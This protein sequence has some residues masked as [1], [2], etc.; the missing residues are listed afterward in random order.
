MDALRLRRA[1]GA[2]RGAILRK[3]TILSAVALAAFGWSPPAGALDMN[4][5]WA[6]IVADGVS[7]EIGVGVL[8]RGIASGSTVPWVQGG[9]GAIAVLGE[10][11]GEWGPKGLQMLREGKK[12]GAIADTV[13]MSD[14]NF[15]RMQFGIVDRDGTPGG[16]TGNLVAGWCGGQLNIGVAAQGNMMS[17]ASVLQAL[18]DS[19]AANP[20]VPVAERLLHS[21]RAALAA[22]KGGPPMRSAALLVGRFH[23]GRPQD[24]SR[25][26]YLRADDHADPLAEIERLYA[27][28][29]PSRIV[30]ARIAYLDYFGKLGGKVG[31]SRTARE[32]ET[33]RRD[34][35]RAFADP[36][37]QARE[38]NALAW[39]LL[40]NPA[41]LADAER[42]VTKARE[43]EPDNAEL[44]D[45]AAELA[46]RQGKADE[47]LRL[48]KRAA[49]LWP[50]GEAYKSRVVMFETAVGKK[51]AKP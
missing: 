26:V 13:R 11:N 4:G 25:F 22:Q 48:A 37:V 16:F 27:L 41:Y 46:S 17:D 29:V 31:P 38:L 44:L 50:Y 40:R 18:Y 12:P 39:S 20:E 51:A 33:I 24:A 8:S 9:V 36:R 28:D 30:G 47:A 23:P 43:L 5:S 34:I 2:T 3:M 42:A 10:V 32:K 49:E 6:I 35:D 19:S 21:M 7:G 1:A 15:A 14:P 45:T